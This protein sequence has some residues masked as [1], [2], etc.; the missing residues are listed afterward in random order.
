MASSLQEIYSSEVITYSLSLKVGDSDTCTVHPTDDFTFVDREIMTRKFELPED[1]TE[2]DLLDL[3]W[4]K[5]R[6]MEE[7]GNLNRMYQYNYPDRNNGACSFR[8]TSSI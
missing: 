6:H 1:P 5:E 2:R 3:E 7:Y 4:G 8:F